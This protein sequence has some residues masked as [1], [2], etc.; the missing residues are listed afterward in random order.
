[1]SLHSS[2][3]RL[4]VVYLNIVAILGGGERSLLDI[5]DT[6]D[7]TRVEAS[8]IL[9]S[10]GPLQKELRKR[11]ISCIVIDQGKLTSLSRSGSA[12]FVSL[13]TAAWAAIGCMIR[14]TREIRRMH[15]DIVHSNSYKT[16]FLSLLI[17]W[18]THAQLVWHIREIIRDGREGRWFRW[19]SRTIPA[20]VICNSRATKQSLFA[21]NPCAHSSVIH[22]ALDVRHFAEADRTSARAAWT[23]GEIDFVVLLIGMW[24]PLKGQLRMIEA[25]PQLLQ[26]LPTAKLLLVGGEAYAT[27]D[28]ALDGYAQTIHQ[29]IAELDL[30]SHI[31]LAGK[32]NDPA[33]A[34]AAADAVVC[35]SDPPESFGRMIVEAMAAG[36]PAVSYNHGGPAELIQ[37]NRTG[38]LIPVGNEE[39]LAAILQTWATKPALRAELGHTAQTIA[40]EQFDRAQ[41]GPACLDLYAR[42]CPNVGE[43]A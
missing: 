8:V 15:A 28:P 1:M 17:P 30:H 23:F 12:S 16:H 19:L 36:K 26:L 21:D 11:D 13:F 18:F 39:Q 22:N 14:L 9:F 4:R 29:R 10:P 3:P 43:I 38:A 41:L 31:I 2:Q 7:P 6:L 20:H 33:P 5:I 34:F 32:I 27:G 35:L 40:F 42:L 24:C 37:P 25:M